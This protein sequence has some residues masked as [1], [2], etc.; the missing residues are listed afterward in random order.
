MQIAFKLHG[1]DRARKLESTA[2]ITEMMQQLVNLYLANCT[3]SK[4]CRKV[5]KTAR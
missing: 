1:A 4:A 2:T 3:I 5:A